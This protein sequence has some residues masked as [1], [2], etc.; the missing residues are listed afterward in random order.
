MK[1]HEQINGIKTKDDLADFV[2]ALGADFAADPGSWENPNLERF[3]GAM[4][5]WIRSMN[6]YYKNAGQVPHDQPTWKTL[7]DILMAAKLYE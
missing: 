4:E 3:L 5:D 7:A 6:H 1:L 2:A